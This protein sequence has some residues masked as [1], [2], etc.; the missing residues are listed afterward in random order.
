MNTYKGKL[1]TSMSYKEILQGI[2]ELN[3]R[4]NE[5]P[6][7]NDEKKEHYNLVSE[8]NIRSYEAKLYKKNLKNLG[9]ISR[10][11]YNRIVQ[12]CDFIIG[13]MFKLK[14][15]QEFALNSKPFEKIKQII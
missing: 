9:N 8:M 2:N 11:K 15:D 6:L 13:D 10:P 12:L 3:F 5:R 4:K 1:L 14:N 7:T